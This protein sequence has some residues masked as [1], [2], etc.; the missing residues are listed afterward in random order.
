MKVYEEVTRTYLMP[1]GYACIRVDGRSFHTWV[2]GLHKPF[3]DG[4]MEDM[5]LTAVYLCENIQNTK[6]GYVQSDEIS[7]ITT[8]F[9]KLETGM[10]FDGNIQK[11]SSVVASMAT[12]RFNVL[13]SARKSNADLP[14]GRETEEPAMFDCRCWNVPNNWEAYNTLV[15]RQQDAVRNSISAVSQHHYGHKELHSKSQ[16]DMHEML[17]TKGVNWAKDFTDGEKNGRVIVKETYT[18]PN[19]IDNTPMER[20]RWVA[21]GAWEFTKDEGKLLDMIPSY[22]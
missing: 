19:R 1:R 8:N 14:M 20:T 10:F 12:A 15:W 3:D 4:L 18:L 6:V 11:I 7:I 22:V 17:H 5:D 21:K 9:D 13:R 16:S 2:R